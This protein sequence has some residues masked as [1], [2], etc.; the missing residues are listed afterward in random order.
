MKLAS[1]KGGRDGRLVVVSNDLAWFTEAHHIAPTLQVALDQW[2]GCE[3][4]L[5]GLAEGLEHGAV[6]KERFHEH[7]A[8]SPLPRAYQRLVGDGTRQAESDHFL[9]PREPISLGAAGALDL[10]IS[11]VAITGDVPRGATPEQALAAVRLVMLCNEVTLRDR[12]A[13]GVVLGKPACAFSPVAVTPDVLPGW[14][15]GKLSGAL[16]VE[17]NG[18]ALAEVEPGSAPDF[19]ALIAQAARVRPL[20]AGTI[21]DAGPVAKA[22]DVQAGDTVRIA[23]RDAKRHTVFGAIEQTVGE[24]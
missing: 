8:A 20:A 6:P 11:V 2:Q 1:L 17:L 7:Q 13:V 15:G 19:G 3:P 16:E 22:S 9:G 23:L 14:T 18:K 4:A 12:R 10:E 24:G 21:V 5:R